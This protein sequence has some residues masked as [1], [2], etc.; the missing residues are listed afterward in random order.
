[1]IGTK[2]GA[3]VARIEQLRAQF[4]VERAVRLVAVSKTKPVEDL[5]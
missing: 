2:V 4:K 5:V 1:M 3:V